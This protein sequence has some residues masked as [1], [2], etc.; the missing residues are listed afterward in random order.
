M[1]TI[2]AK[3]MRSPFG[4]VADR[5]VNQILLPVAHSHIAIGRPGE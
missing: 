1:R 2:L 3:A 5:L 4:A